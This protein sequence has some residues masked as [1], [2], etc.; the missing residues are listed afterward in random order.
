VPS[1]KFARPWNAEMLEA[2]RAAF[3]HIHEERADLER[4]I[5]ASLSAALPSAVI[6]GRFDRR[7]PV[8]DARQH[9]KA[10]ALP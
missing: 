2:R 10:R 1:P 4:P 9:R 6:H 8:T 5:G 7:P 3:R